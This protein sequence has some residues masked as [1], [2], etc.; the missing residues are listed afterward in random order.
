MKTAVIAGAT[1]LVGDQLLSR[2][3]SASRY[4]TV[5]ALTRRPLAM[6][7]AKLHTVISDFH[8]LD[9][10]LAQVKP[11]DVYCCLG[12]TMARAGSKKKFY[13]VDFEF[14]YA[15]AKITSGLGAK[16]YLLVSA[17]GADKNSRIYYNKVKGEVEA[18]IRSV[19]FDCIHILRPSLL[20]GPRTEKRPGE[21]VAKF[22]HKI[23]AFVI[24]EKYKAID[25]G[26]VAEA[27]LTLAS[28]DQSGTFIH[29]SKKIQHFGW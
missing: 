24:P 4:S 16:Q 18:A 13:E 26:K 29:E 2:L 1:G 25:A 5:I 8:D 22:F 21:D 28:K 14:P 27:M 11:D 23:F 6:N 9:S 19:P 15:L 7:H 3:L 12:T 17:L 20:L 10:V